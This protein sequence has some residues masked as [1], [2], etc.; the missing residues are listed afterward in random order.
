MVIVW[1]D[2]L[3]QRRRLQRFQQPGNCQLHQQLSVRKSIMQIKRH[4]IELLALLL[5]GFATT[6]ARA[7]LPNP[8]EP[9][10]N[11]YSLPESGAWFDPSDPGTGFFWE[12]QNGTLVGTYFGFD[13]S[14]NSL[15]LLFSG[16]LLAGQVVD[17]KDPEVLWSVDADLNRFANGKCIADCATGQPDNA[18]ET[19]ESAGT[20]R[21]E[22][23]GRSLAR[24][25]IDGG[26]M[27]EVVPLLFGVPG[28]NESPETSKLFMPVLTGR[29]VFVFTSG[30]FRDNSHD[31]QQSDAYV[32]EIGPPNVSSKDSA[33]TLKYTVTTIDFMDNILSTPMTC[34]VG[35]CSIELNNLGLF[36]GGAFFATRNISDSRLMAVPQAPLAS[37]P[38]PVRLDAFRLGYD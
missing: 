16:P 2:Q 15:W 19:T 3:L 24:F 5:V 37:P 27:H 4:T 36:P 25:S 34:N 10:A 9:F 29:W 6:M 20:I 31:M 23:L 8:D 1:C 33:K 21:V 18:N 12:L 17:N 32:V 11:A 7:A 30:V 28:F 35:G 22:I 14:G 13:E 26:S 38:V